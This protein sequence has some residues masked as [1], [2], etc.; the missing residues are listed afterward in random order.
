VKIY[1]S[2][3]MEGASG[4]CSVEQTLPGTP[5]YAEARE[6]LLSDVNAAV[7]GA[8]RAGASEITVVDAHYTSFNLPHGRVHPVARVLYGGQ[9]PSPR[10]PFLDGSFD[11]LFLIAYHA[12]AGTH[13]AVLEHTM[14]S[15]AWHRA[16]VNSRE[17]GEIGIDAAYAGAL[18][19]PVTLV[20]GDDK[21]CAEAREWLGRIETVEV[22]QGLARHQALCLSLETTRKRICAAAQKAARLKVKP[23]CINGP[24][25]VTIVYKSASAADCAER[26]QRGSIRVDGYTVKQKFKA[27]TDWFGIEKIRS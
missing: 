2:V 10:F 23:L 12:K 17:I 11:A 9:A 16:L 22:K 19:V 5:Q 13:K 24:A 4:V 8:H 20:T 18:G 3:D 26:D 14:S 25:E 21:A 1:I 7:E 15:T 6:L 27:F